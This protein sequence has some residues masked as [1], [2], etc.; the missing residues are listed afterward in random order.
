[1]KATQTTVAMKGADERELVLGRLLG[2]S[3]LAMSGRLGS[4]P[5]SAEGALKVRVEEHAP[6]CTRCAALH[7]LAARVYIDNDL[8]AGAV[9]L[10]LLFT[11]CLLSV[12]GSFSWVMFPL[13]RESFCFFWL[14]L[15][16]F[17]WRVVFPLRVL[18]S[19]IYASGQ[20]WSFTACPHPCHLLLFCL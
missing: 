15:Y 4:E 5:E 6:S 16:G 13:F 2:V 19:T 17:Y 18:I 7:A 8:H 20:G 11:V 3:A 10:V 12:G 1:M 9:V 14:I